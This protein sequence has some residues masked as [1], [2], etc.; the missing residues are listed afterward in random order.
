MDWASLAAL[1]NAKILIIGDVMM[2][3]YWVGDTNR[4]SPEAPVPVVKINQDQLRPGGA[5]NVALNAAS[6]GAAKVQL[7]AATG[8]DDT[9]DQLEG[10]LS[11][12]G[13]TCHFQRLPGYNTI[14]KTRV[15]SHDQQLVRLDM[16]QPYQEND[17]LT[18]LPLAKQAIAEA[19]V[20]I[21]SDYGKGA[22]AAFEEV[23]LLAASC[24]VPL[25]VDPK[26]DD[27]S[28]Y[29]GA[30]L[31]TPNF[32]EFQEVAGPC[33]N[34][35]ILY[36]QAEKLLQEHELQALLVTRGKL[37]MTLFQQD[38][39]PVN[40]ATQ[41]KEVYDVS[42]A[43]DTVIAAMA[44]AIAAKLPLVEAADLANNAA[45]IVVG[46]LGTATVSNHELMSHCGKAMLEQFGVVDLPSAKK[47]REMLQLQGK[48]LV[49]T[50]GCFDLLHPGH[51]QYLREARELGDFLMVAVNSDCS[52]S[53]LKGP[54]RPINN[55]DS[56]MTMLAALEMVDWVI[57]FSE[58][59]PES[60]YAELL[61]DVLVKGGDYKV[62]EVAGHRQVLANG[63]EVK[64]LSFLPNYSSTAII[65]R[66]QGEALEVS[67]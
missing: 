1:K 49:M 31:I 30:T 5:A 51:L 18:L 45:G 27:F 57:P 21:F 16:E 65:E 15:M 39:A 55:L 20:V 60:L 44:V 8:A 2:D 61:P 29:R 66:I 41:A 12:Q 35:Q 53:R 26:T 64:I 7:V 52:V 38:A 54:A 22:L 17:V 34:E 6:L 36:Q 42:G 9:A 59:T 28:A 43:G 50:N 46:K 47:L 40:L 11:E 67:E 14:T 23:A 25:L 10:L 48:R 24:R 58:D 33:P 13:V 37:G 62:E 63:G 3:R 56:R 4:I 19:D 32:K